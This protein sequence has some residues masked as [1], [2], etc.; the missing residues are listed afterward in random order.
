MQQFSGV[1][2]Q[3]QQESLMAC[4]PAAGSTSSQQTS[5][6]CCWQEHHTHSST[7]SVS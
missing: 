6:H 7:I 3:S 2:R 1:T 5:W 4:L